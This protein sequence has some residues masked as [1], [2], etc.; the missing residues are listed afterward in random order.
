[1]NDKNNRRPIT[2]TDLSMGCLNDKEFNI[3]NEYYKMKIPGT[4][5]IV[6]LRSQVILMLKNVRENLP[7]GY[8][9]K[10]YDGYRS[11]KTQKYLFQSVVKNIIKNEGISY[12]HALV[13]TSKYFT[14]PD[15]LD[16]ND[17]PHNTGGAVDLTLTY[18]G[19]KIS[20]G[21]D[22][23]ETDEISHT[24]YFERPYHEF[25]GLSSFEWGRVRENRRILITAMIEEGFTN[26]ENEWW[27][28]DY[29]NKFWADRTG[30]KIIF[31]QCEDLVEGL[32]A[33]NP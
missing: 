30:N 14:N 4:D 15:E 22:F 11:L 17:I 2:K 23:D 31:G 29:G 20:M 21:S 32:K 19:N 6:Y 1:M 5:P 3:S 25:S 7:E 10:I 16:P 9:L 8:D 28:F 33:S 27:H 18:Q 12:E 24:A 26:Y 13:K